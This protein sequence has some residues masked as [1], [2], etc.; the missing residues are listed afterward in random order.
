MFRGKKKV[1]FESQEPAEPCT[2]VM[3]KEWSSV[4]AQAKT[5]P[6][7]AG[8]EIRQGTKESLGCSKKSVWSTLLDILEAHIKGGYGF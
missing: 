4:G 8:G 6:L 1:L 3:F 2:K 7:V 5:E